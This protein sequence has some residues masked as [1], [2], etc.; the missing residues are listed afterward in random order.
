MN[1]LC[2]KMA[3]SLSLCVAVGLIMSSALAEQQGYCVKDGTAKHCQ[4]NQPYYSCIRHE[5][6]G[7]HRWGVKMN[8]RDCG[9]CYCNESTSGA[10][11]CPDG[12]HFGMTANK[13][14]GCGT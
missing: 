7:P 3:V 5:G 4:Q 13:G 9:A 10:P 6:T 11:K 1:I 8:D 14:C 2:K 12:C